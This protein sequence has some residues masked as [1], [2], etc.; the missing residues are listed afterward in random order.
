LLL[1]GLSAYGIFS[2]SLIASVA[3]FRAAAP[4]ALSNF[5]CYSPFVQG[6]DWHTPAQRTNTAKMKTLP[7]V[8]LKECPEECDLIFTV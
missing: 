3:G 5:S 8:F 1:Y 2:F 6:D 7:A 4:D